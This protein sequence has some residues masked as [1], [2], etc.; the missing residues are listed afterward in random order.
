MATAREIIAD[1]LKNAGTPKPAPSQEERDKAHAE[2]IASLKKSAADYLK[3]T[4]NS[5]YK[6]N[7]EVD[8]GVKTYDETKRIPLNKR[9]AKDVSFLNANKPN[10]AK[11]AK[12]EI[13][14]KHEDGS[15]SKEKFKHDGKTSAEEMGNN[16]L[17]HMQ[18]LHSKFGGFSKPVSVHKAVLKEDVEVNDDELL[19]EELNEM[20]GAGMGTKD[21]HKHL[22]KMGWKLERSKGGHD[23][24][25]HEKST[26]N[27]AVPRHKGDLS[28]PTVIAI[29][30]NAK[31]GEDV[32]RLSFKE[33]LSES[34]KK[35]QHD[36]VQQTLADHDINSSIKDGKVVVHKDHVS[37]AK[38][39][40]K[41]IGYGD[42]HVVHEEVEIEE[43]VEV[44]DEARSEY[45][46]NQHLA[47]NSSVGGAKAHYLKKDG[48][49]VSGPHKNS[50]DA[51][52]A[53]NGL[54]DRKGIKIVHEDVEELDEISKATLGSYVKKA[55]VS[56]AVN[57][58]KYQSS[59]E[60]SDREQKTYQKYNKRIKGIA[61]ATDRLTKEDIIS[62]EFDLEMLKEDLSDKLYAHIDSHRASGKNV[63]VTDYGRDGRS[64]TF[65]SVDKDGTKRKHTVTM[66]GSKHEVIE[67][68]EKE[69]NNSSDNQ[70]R[71]RGRPAGSKSGAR[72]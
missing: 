1:K 18:L 14:I 65:I 40:L 36:Y 27:I 56:A 33:Y 69:E 6:K 68:G 16:H 43:N 44:I 2:H 15:I 50:D 20:L 58:A 45:E 52:K 8:E 66:N 11:V 4:P 32:E 64:A 9:S 63:K 59:E 17:K 72:N 28:A 49:R 10:K 70:K 54:S 21:V 5:I 23:V 71:G 47:N 67:K 35:L 51:L 26:K 3:K 46:A 61:K 34:E 22:K 13:H 42:M 62:G 29:L 12:V 24:F 30:K 48:R 19:I 25:T 31:I 41:K 37:S 53:W 57:A 60:G 39:H 55:S 38:K 7:E